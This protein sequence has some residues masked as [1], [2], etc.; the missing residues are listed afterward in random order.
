MTNSRELGRVVRLQIQSSSLKLGPPKGRY[1]DPAP[2]REVEV[3]DLDTHGVSAH[4][5]GCHVIDVHNALH[6]DTKNRNGINAISFGFT[7]HYQRMRDE[8]AGHLVNGIAGENILIET[9]ELV[10]LEAVR[11]GVV[12]LGAEGR[13]IELVDISVAHPCVE[14][15]RYALADPVAEPRTVS[16]ALRFLENGMRGYYA[17]VV[18]TKPLRIEPGD[19][20]MLIDRDATVGKG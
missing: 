8:F 10:E 1:Y 9:D 20:V 14:F 5:N 17:A 12:I 15:S 4:L 19:R 13:R 6:P 2:L 18:T 11:A 7:G 3:L 16:T